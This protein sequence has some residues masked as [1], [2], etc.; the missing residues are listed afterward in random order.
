MHR[1]DLG[2][3][4]HPKDFFFFKG[5]E[6]EPMITPKSISLIPAL[7]TGTMECYHF[8]ST[9][10]GLD[11]GC[12]CGGYRLFKHFFGSSFYYWGDSC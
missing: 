12:K 2:L 5:M 9:F 6:S 1:L 10:S 4:S 11:F 8:F 3:Y 7:F